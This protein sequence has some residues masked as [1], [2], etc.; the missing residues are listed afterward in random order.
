MKKVAMIISIALFLAVL[1]ASALADV[2]WNDGTTSQIQYPGNYAIRGYFPDLSGSTPVYLIPNNSIPIY[3]QN[4]SRQKYYGSYQN[5]YNPYNR[6]YYQRYQ[7]IGR[8]T[9]TIWGMQ[10]NSIIQWNSMSPEKYEWSRGVPPPSWYK[11]YVYGP[12]KTTDQF[13]NSRVEEESE[14]REGKID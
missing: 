13:N 3:G 8:G 10:D 6:G 5:Y 9:T 12:P 14:E 4:Y 1:S 11:P 7:R 2:Y